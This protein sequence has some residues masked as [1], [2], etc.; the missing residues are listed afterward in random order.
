MHAV[1]V[2]LASGECSE[3][4]TSVESAAAVALINSVVVAVVVMLT[5]SHLVT[6]NFD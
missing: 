1:V 5:H 6:T 2:T 4:V 3:R